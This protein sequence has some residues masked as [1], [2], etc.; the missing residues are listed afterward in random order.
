MKIIEFNHK[1]VI[2]L[3]KKSVEEH[4][5]DDSKDAWFRFTDGSTVCIHMLDPTWDSYVSLTELDRDNGTCF[6]DEQNLEYF[7]ITDRPYTL[8]IVG[9]YFDKARYYYHRDFS[10]YVKW[11]Y[12]P[13]IELHYYEPGEE[14]GRNDS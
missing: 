2:P 5:L 10:G 14:I 13:V 4:W 9:I 3:L 12:L 6:Y 11:E 7:S 1:T 8:R